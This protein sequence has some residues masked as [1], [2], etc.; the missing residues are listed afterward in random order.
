MS[1]WVSAQAK[2]IRL[3]QQHHDK[4]QSVDR[5]FHLAATL[6]WTPPLNLGYTIAMTDQPVSNS[7]K[8]AK[9]QRAQHRENRL[10]AALK[11]NMAKRKQQVRGRSDDA[12][13]NTHNDKE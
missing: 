10:K 7:G 5:S 1:A 9:S 3:F 2:P 6:I 11:A 4:T 8:P 12:D 13:P